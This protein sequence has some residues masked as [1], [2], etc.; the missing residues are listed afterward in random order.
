MTILQELMAVNEAIDIFSLLEPLKASMPQVF[1][2]YL[3]YRILFLRSWQEHFQNPCQ[4]C[5]Q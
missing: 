1:Q 4:V 5:C 3:T 2:R